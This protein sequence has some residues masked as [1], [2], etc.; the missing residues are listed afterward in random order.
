MTNASVEIRAFEPEY[1]EAICE[2][3]EP[4][5]VLELALAG[6]DAKALRPLPEEEDI[7]KF[8]ELNTAL[9]AYIDGR[10]VGFVAWRDGGYLSWLYVDPKHHRCGIGNRLLEE[11]MS[12]LGPQAWTLVK[13]GNDAAISLYQKHGMEVVRSRPAD[14]W[15]HP[16]TELRLALPTSRKY[17][18][19]VPNFGA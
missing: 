7:D 15:G 16:H 14:T 19:D 4:A 8:V 2:F 13:V 9:L 1:W 17:D 18:H 12:F 10:A 5:A 6:V 3:Y 11:A